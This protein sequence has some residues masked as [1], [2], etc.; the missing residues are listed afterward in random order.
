M[1]FSLKSA[2]LA[3]TLMM[4]GCSTMTG[5]N[6]RTT[7]DNTFVCTAFKPISWMKS[8]TKQTIRE[9]KEH[10]AVLIMLC[11]EHAPKQSLV[12]SIDGD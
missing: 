6:A 7:T 5:S 1:H 11:P 10:N 2:L 12:D 4:A 8:D 3:A 9:V